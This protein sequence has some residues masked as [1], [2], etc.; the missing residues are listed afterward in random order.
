MRLVIS[1]GGMSLL[2]LGFIV[3]FR[4]KLRFHKALLAIF[5][6]LTLTYLVYVVIVSIFTLFFG[7][8]LMIGEFLLTLS[9]AVLIASLAYEKIDGRGVFLT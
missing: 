6:G 8:Y 9:Y 1:A 4:N 7:R 3:V 5:I 2:L